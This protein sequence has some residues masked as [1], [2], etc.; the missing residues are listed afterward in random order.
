MYME[1]GATWG[2]TASTPDLLPAGTQRGASSDHTTSSGGG[3][4]LEGKR[5]GGVG[6]AGMGKRKKEGQAV[7]MATSLPGSYTWE[8]LLRDRAEMA[9][10]LGWKQPPKN[11]KSNSSSK[12]GEV[13][14]GTAQAQEPKPLGD[15]PTSTP[16]PAPTTSGSANSTPAPTPPTLGARAQADDTQGESSRRF[17]LSPS[18]KSVVRSGRTEIAPLPQETAGDRGESGSAGGG[19]SGVPGGQQLPVLE[20]SESGA[21]A[22]GTTTSSSQLLGAQHQETLGAAAVS[23]DDAYRAQGSRVQSLQSQSREGGLLQPPQPRESEGDNMEDALSF[24]A[25]SISSR[26]TPSAAPTPD[27]CD[28]DREGGGALF[29]DDS[30]YPPAVA[31]PSLGA[32]LVGDDSTRA[33]PNTNTPPSPLEV[34][35]APEGKAA[36][37]SGVGVSEGGGTGVGGVDW[38][39]PPSPSGVCVCVCVCVW[40]IE[41]HVLSVFQ[42]WP[43]MLIRARMRLP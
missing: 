8:R 15:V 20:T 6:V 42:V 28:A 9:A 33:S 17:S 40:R 27:P 32:A 26:R 11:K 21:R 22:E 30:Y 24:D 10:Q 3:V 37:G 25:V 13:G 23:D 2:P 16:A 12:G 31:T 43:P 14:S 19:P 41:L 38:M 35:S 36:A 5:A 34:V 39:T 4:P 1:E 7:V 29:G 18:V